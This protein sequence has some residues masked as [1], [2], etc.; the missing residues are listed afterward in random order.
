MPGLYDAHLHLHFPALAPHRAAVLAD[1]R[2][3]EVRGA[4]VNGTCEDEWPVVAALA[5][6]H[7]WV[8]PAFGVHPWD[9]GNRSPDWLPR[10]RAALVAEPR[11]GV[12][13]IGLD[14]LITDHLPPDDPRLKGLRVAPLAEQRE[15]LVRQFEL[16]AELDRPASLHCF[17]AAGALHDVLRASALPRR[18][19]LLHAYSGPIELVRPFAELGAY[20]SYNAHFLQARHEP[21]NRVFAAVPLDRLLVETDAPAMAPPVAR[22]KFPLP[23]DHDGSAVNHPGNILAAYAAL[24]ELRHVTLGELAA[25]VEENFRRLFM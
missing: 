13:E 8:V 5:R 11:A 4:V 23:P 25:R 18:G 16:A 7:P 17:R 14:R 19:F 15:V 10:L 3:I 22:R 24:A 20:F 6:E 1:L 12:G 2:R 9:A 21:R